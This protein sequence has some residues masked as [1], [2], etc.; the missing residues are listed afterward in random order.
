[1][2]VIMLGPPGAGKGTQAQLMVERFGIPQISTGDLLRK[3]I[4]EGTEL[5]KTARGFIDDGK[6]VPDDLMI[7]LIKERIA[8]PDCEDGYILDG[9]PR[10]LEQARAMENADRIDIVL[11]IVVDTGVLMD[12]LMGRRTCRDCNAVYN[13]TGRPPKIEGKCDSCG[14]ELFQRDDDNEATVTKRLD[15]YRSQTEPLIEFY[16]GKGILRDVKTG[17]EIPETFGYVLVALEPFV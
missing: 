1:M 6:L 12:R 3:A 10:T 11:N 15:T 8:E 9:F 16:R 7:A 13:I 14:G 17:K 5:G 4:G 2:K